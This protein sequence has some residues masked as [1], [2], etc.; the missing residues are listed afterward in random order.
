MIDERV[1]GV[2]RFVDAVT[3]L[4]VDIPLRLST[5]VEVKWIRTNRGVFAIRFSP[6]LDGS[7]S[8]AADATPGSIE[9]GITVSDPSGQYLARRRTLR[10][11]RDADIENADDP[12]PALPA[13]LDPAQDATVGSL[14]KPIDVLLFPA[15][16]MQ[17][18]PGW[19]AVRATIVGDTADSRLANALVRVLRE[20]EDETT[21]L[22]NALSDHRGEA[23]IA[24]T[25][26]PA[27]SFNGGNGPVM[28]PGADVTLEI[29]F[30]PSA[31]TPPDPF[32]LEQ[33]REDLL[34]RTIPLRLVPGRVLVETL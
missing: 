6:G 15:P 22:G 27:T 17:V 19:A 33:R 25:G 11:P 18:A 3:R 24:V 9:V 30:D 5:D 28:L 23:L 8:D 4:P 7:D 29:V 10:L 1:L 32:D 12:A 16:K 34:V 31:P 26:I 13:D 20:D 14:F 2:I 21:H